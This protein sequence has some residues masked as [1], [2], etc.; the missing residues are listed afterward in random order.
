MSWILT[1]VYEATKSPEHLRKAI[2][3]WEKEIKSLDEETRAN[4][5]AELYW[6]IAKSQDLLGEYLNASESFK[7]ASRFYQLTGEKTPEFREFYKEYASYMEAWSEFE[8]GKQAHLE[9]NYSQAQNNYLKISE[10]Y[11]TTEQWNYLAT[12]FRAWASLEEAEE[13]SRK[14]KPQEAIQSFQNAYDLFKTSKTEAQEK[15]VHINEQE[16]ETHDIVNRITE[17]L[18]EEDKELK[19]KPSSTKDTEEKTQLR[20]RVDASG[21][22]ME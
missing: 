15:L 10:I 20:K 11:E 13:Y 9:K 14:E 21:Q 5:I 22:R 6:S 19:I 2:D 7:E 16:K 18:K 12:N 17:Q 4:R 1:H 3:I 8:K